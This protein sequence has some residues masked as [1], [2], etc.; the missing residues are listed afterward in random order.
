MQR[1]GGCL[2]AAGLMLGGAAGAVLHIGAWGMLA[3]LAAGGAAAAA[4]NWWAARG[5]GE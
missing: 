4:F 5:G 3:G 1:G 2:L